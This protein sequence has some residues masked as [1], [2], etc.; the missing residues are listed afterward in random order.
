MGDIAKLPDHIRSLTVSVNFSSDP[1][2]RVNLQGRD[3]GA[4]DAAEILI[5]RLI[6]TARKEYPDG[7]PKILVQL[8]AESPDL[9]EP[10]LAVIDQMLDNLKVS[11]EGTRVSVNLA[12]LKGLDALAARLG[13]VLRP[14]VSDQPP[15]VVVKKVDEKPV[16][17]KV[18]DRPFV[19]EGKEPAVLRGHRN[20]VQSVAISADGSTLVSAGADKMVKIWDLKT[21]KERFTLKG[22]EEEVLTVAITPDGKLAASAGADT[23]IK[24]WDVETGKERATLKGHEAR[25]TGIALT[26]DGKM[27]VSGSSDRTVRL[28]DVEAGKETKILEGHAK[29][30]YAV[31]I[32]PDGKT[33]VSAD[34]DARIKLWDTATGKDQDR[35]VGHFPPIKA[36]AISADGKTLASGGDKTARVIEAATGKIVHKFDHPSAVN[37]VALAQDGKLV[38]SVCGNPPDGKAEVKVWE[39]ATGK[40]IASFD[41]PSDAVTCVAVTPDGSLTAFGVYVLTDPPV[42]VWKL[43]PA[44]KE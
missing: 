1:L 44:M 17:K 36:I 30:I 28:W 23:L 25:V 21:G 42:R 18:E 13:P 16:L 39:A 6:E 10:A 20:V 32:T 12:A 40:V 11:K 7:R 2:L 14:L 22:H 26:A 29:P 34:G 9:P 5:N 43:P 3:A 27:L 24:I 31:A 38:V 15:P 33:A 35:F 8:K 4:A 19:L 41:E 37:A